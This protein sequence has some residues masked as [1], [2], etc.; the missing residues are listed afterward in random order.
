MY[1]PQNILCYLESF[2][3]SVP[4]LPS[5]DELRSNTRPVFK[6][7]ELRKAVITAYSFHDYA[8][9]YKEQI[10]NDTRNKQ[11]VLTSLVSDM[12]VEYKYVLELLD[13]YKSLKPNEYG[14]ILMDCGFIPPEN[15]AVFD[16]QESIKT[17]V[18]IVEQI[19]TL[20]SSL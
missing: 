16:N 11:N 6:D 7:N 10:N 4:Q 5:E 2:F 1:I 8:T 17:F 9:R 3:D 18:S 15:K 20:K 14:K 19:T 12:D 13:L